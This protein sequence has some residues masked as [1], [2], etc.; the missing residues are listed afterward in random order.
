MV[1]PQNRKTNPCQNISLQNDERLLFK[2]LLTVHS[3]VC[4]RTEE[5]Q[6]DKL[7]ILYSRSVQPPGK[8]LPFDNPVSIYHVVAYVAWGYYGDSDGAVWSPWITPYVRVV[9]SAV[10]SLGL[11]G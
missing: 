7:P 3:S 1:G 8:V 9:V 4:G 11:T 10:P 2:A 5:V 6:R